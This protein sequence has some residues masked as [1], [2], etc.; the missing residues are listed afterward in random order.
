[1]LK[2][3]IDATAFGGLPEGVQSYYKKGDDGSFSLQVEDDSGELRRAKEREA[4]GRRSAEKRVTELEEEIATLSGM[5]AD[6]RKDVRLLEQSYQDKIKTVEKDLTVK[7]DGKNKTITDL[8]VNSNATALASALGGQNAAILMPHVRSRINV[9]LTGEE[10][11]LRILDKEG[12]VSALTVD[13][14]KKEFLEDKTFSAIIVGSKA[15]GSGAPGGHEGSGRASGK[16]PVDKPFSAMG[17]DEYIAA[18]RE[19]IDS[20]KQ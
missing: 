5:D 12:K 15:T 16:P 19:T 4:V 8:L 13:D 6:K 20:R 7:L 1:M 14:L 10:P 11:V 2:R 9:D 3:K 18:M 17:K